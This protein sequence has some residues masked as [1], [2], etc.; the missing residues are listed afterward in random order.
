MFSTDNFDSSSSAGKPESKRRKVCLVTG[1]LMDSAGKNSSPCKS[2]EEFCIIRQK[3]E[4]RFLPFGFLQPCPRD[5]VLSWPFS[6]NIETSLL[7]R[8]AGL[9]ARMG[10]SCQSKLSGSLPNE[11]FFDASPSRT[12]QLFVSSGVRGAGLKF[13]FELSK[14]YPSLGVVG[15]LMK[16]LR[17][18]V[19]TSII[20]W[21]LWLVVSRVS[22]SKLWVLSFE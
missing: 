7:E 16:S 8:L 1:P 9:N 17:R 14:A 20:D 3:D 21:L 11:S 15:R 2:S 12:S 22:F 10:D 5:G 13:R 6:L 19:L 4:W 18:N